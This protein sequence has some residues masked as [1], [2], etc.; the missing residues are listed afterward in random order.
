MSDTKFDTKAQFIEAVKEDGAELGGVEYFTEG[1][2]SATTYH[3]R[4][5][6]GE[7]VQVTKAEIEAVWD[8]LHNGDDEE[9]EADEDDG[10]EEVHLGTLYYS[11]SNWDQDE[12]RETLEKF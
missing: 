5:D 7:E 11:Q 9:D 12:D 3:A 6:D 4:G 1:V 2:G 8:E 10:P